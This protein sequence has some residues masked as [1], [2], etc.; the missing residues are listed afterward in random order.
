MAEFVLSFAPAP[1]EES[2]V[3]VVPVASDPNTGDRS[4]VVERAANGGERAVAMQA[5]IT[6]SHEWLHAYCED[7]KEEA[8]KVFE[9]GGAALGSTSLDS[10]KTSMRGALTAVVQDARTV[11]HGRAP[12][13]IV[14]ELAAGFPAVEGLELDGGNA[15]IEATVRECVENAVDIALELT[16]DAIEDGE[17]DVRAFLTTQGWRGVRVAVTKAAAQ[18]DHTRM[19]AYNDLDANH[20]GVF[21]FEILKDEDEL[22]GQGER[23]KGDQEVTV[24]LALRWGAII[25]KV[26]CLRCRQ[27]DGQFTILAIPFVGPP[28]HDHC[29]CVTSLW[30]I[31]WTWEDDE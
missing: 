4:P 31:T 30:P 27:R 29:R 19:A 12:T 2:A 23:A 21:G 16:R 20:A 24:V 18:Y 10:L 15:P 17:S 6:R 26:T 8:R 11:V 13:D 22:P 25:D 3:L 7:L 1:P 5:R 14:E 9:D 28:L